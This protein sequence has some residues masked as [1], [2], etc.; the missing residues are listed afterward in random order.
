MLQGLFQAVVLV[1]GALLVLGAAGKLRQPASF[2]AALAQV[3]GFSS[4]LMVRL[5]AL[6]ELAV[7]AAALLGG[8]GYGAL[9]TVD[10]VMVAFLLRLRHVAP[11]VSC[12]C[13]GASDTSTSTLHLGLNAAFGAAAIGALVYGVDITVVPDSIVVA[14]LWVVALAVLVRLVYELFVMAPS[15]PIPVP[16][17]TRRSRTS[18]R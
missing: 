3:I 15:R 6:I 11:D 16:V 5:A 8:F 4:P 1:N 18:T 9:A 2:S 13:F 12:G 17:R 14:G 7:A 10:I